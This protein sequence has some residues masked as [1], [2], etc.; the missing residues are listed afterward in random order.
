MYEDEEKRYK[1]IEEFDLGSELNYLGIP[2]FHRYFDDK[3]NEEILIIMDY[4]EGKELE[5]IMFTLNED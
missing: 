3:F 4:I 1:L 2:K 5:D